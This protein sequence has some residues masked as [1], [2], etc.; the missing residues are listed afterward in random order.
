MHFPAPLVYKC[1]STV[2]ASQCPQVGAHQI[3][4][5]KLKIFKDFIGEVLVCFFLQWPQLLVHFIP[6]GYS[7][8][9][10]P[11]RSLCSFS[12]DLGF[13]FIL[14]WLIILLTFL[15]IWI[16]MLHW[17]GRLCSSSFLPLATSPLLGGHGP[18]LKGLS[19]HT[20]NKYNTSSTFWLLLLIVRAFAPNYIEYVQLC[21]IPA[22]TTA[23][24]T[25]YKIKT[26]LRNNY[27]C[28]IDCCY[29]FVA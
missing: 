13:W 6:E 1:P 5:N 25:T 4:I 17:R 24:K 2:L 10:N 28:S 26:K 18:L 27:I 12:C 11:P 3:N 14:T 20:H 21:L 7:S 9:Y 29:K 23:C 19:S 15:V 22:P 8:R 16:A